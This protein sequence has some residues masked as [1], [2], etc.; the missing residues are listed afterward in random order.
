MTLALLCCCRSLYFHTSEGHRAALPHIYVTET[1]ASVS[2]AAP[3]SPKRVH[4]REEREEP[5][6]DGGEIEEER[7]ET[8]E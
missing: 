1:A 5:C 6:D 8:K 2:P 3:T 7:E 4:F